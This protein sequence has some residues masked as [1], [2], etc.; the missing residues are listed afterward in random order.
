MT[1]SSSGSI[2]DHIIL[3]PSIESGNYIIKVTTQTGSNFKM[4]DN[5]TSIAVKLGFSQSKIV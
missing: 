2:G 4:I 3:H 5:I 1:F